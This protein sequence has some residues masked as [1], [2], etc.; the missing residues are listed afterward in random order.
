MLCI[1]DKMLEEYHKHG[2]FDQPDGL[3]PPT[4]P[5]EAPVIIEFLKFTR[6][7]IS[8]GG[9]KPSPALIAAIIVTVVPLSALVID[10]TCFTPRGA[11]IFGGTWTVDNPVSCKFQTSDAFMSERH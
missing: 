1:F 10:P 3:A 6:G 9:I 7:N 2:P 4:L 8:M 11:N 5:S